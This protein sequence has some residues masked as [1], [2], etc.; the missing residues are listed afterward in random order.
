MNPVRGP[1]PCPYHA[2]HSAVL[3]H[4]PFI[5]YCKQA[6]V[7]AV[8]F[9][10][11]LLS[12]AGFI[13]CGGGGNSGGG[14]NPQPSYILSASPSTLS[15]Y[16]GGSATVTVTGE[17]SNGFSGTMSV[18]FGGLPAGVTASPSSFTLT[19]SGTQQVQL[20]AAST[21]GLGIRR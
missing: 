11:S 8:V 14:P 21:A 1:V 10:V 4:S 7:L 9:A 15:V 3:P 2:L 13:G 19:G 20:N 18:S 5:Y 6:L 16:P 12:I 17:P